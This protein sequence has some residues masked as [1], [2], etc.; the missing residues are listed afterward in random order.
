MRPR[1][2]ENW[3]RAGRTDARLVANGALKSLELE[4]AQVVM[5]MANPPHLDNEQ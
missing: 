4:L 3:R 1:G 5:A 2:H